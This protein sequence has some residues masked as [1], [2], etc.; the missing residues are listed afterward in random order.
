MELSTVSRV[1]AE[2]WGGGGGGGSALGAVVSL[3]GG[4]CAHPRRP[5]GVGRSDPPGPNLTQRGVGA[6]TLAEGSG[7]EHVPLLSVRS[8]ASWRRRDPGLPKGK[9]LQKWG[10]TLWDRVTSV[11]HNSVL[12]GVGSPRAKGQPGWNNWQRSA[13]CGTWEPGQA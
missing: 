10:P 1:W 8:L 12:G 13:S 5:G 11:Q 2:S 6:G 9:L 3:K 7:R 4:V